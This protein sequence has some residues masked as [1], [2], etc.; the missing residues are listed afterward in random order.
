MQ[1]ACAR[2]HQR[3]LWPRRAVP[4][5]QAC[6]ADEQDEKSG[7]RA[8]ERGQSAFATTV[9]ASSDPAT[10]PISE[11]VR[12]TPPRNGCTPNNTSTGVNE[13]AS[14]ARRDTAA[15]RAVGMRWLPKRPYV[16]SGPILLC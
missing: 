11:K 5:V 6:R 7:C 16:S 15:G 3:L 4:T 10:S 12:I 8:E 14:R 1:V 13:E 9:M 2:S